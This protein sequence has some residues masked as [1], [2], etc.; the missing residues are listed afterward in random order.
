VNRPAQLSRVVPLG[1]HL[2]GSADRGGR[3]ADK[4]AA[5]R[6]ATGA[7]RARA[8][9]QLKLLPRTSSSKRKQRYLGDPALLYPRSRPSPVLD[10]EYELQACGRDTQPSDCLGASA[11]SGSTPPTG[12]AACVLCQLGQATVDLGLVCAEGSSG[13]REVDAFDP[14]VFV[15][16]LGHGD[17]P[18]VDVCLVLEQVFNR[19]TGKP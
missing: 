17:D 2:L 19:R 10:P 8:L 14:G 3:V 7:P 12:W 9:A 1:P 4:L 15:K 16:L 6:L 13:V 11:C 5:R 18:A